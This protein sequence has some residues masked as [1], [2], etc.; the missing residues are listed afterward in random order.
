MGYDLRVEA[1][2]IA[3]RT[4]EDCHLMFADSGFGHWWRFKVL[5]NLGIEVQDFFLGR[6]ESPA[7]PDAD[8]K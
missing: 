5:Q 3:R 2:S 6:V 1:R 7:N 8:A 4:I